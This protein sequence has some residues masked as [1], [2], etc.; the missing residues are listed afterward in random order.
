LLGTV[1]SPISI[2]VHWISRTAQF[3]VTSLN[4]R[5]WPASAIPKAY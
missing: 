2:Q 5:S 3:P 1:P 4:L